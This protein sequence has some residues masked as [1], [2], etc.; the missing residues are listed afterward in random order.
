[1][2]F[3]DNALQLGVLPTPSSVSAGAFSGDVSASFGNVTK[4]GKSEIEISF[5]ESISLG[6]GQYATN[7][8]LQEMP[9]PID[10]TVW[11]NYLAVR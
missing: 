3:W 11:G 8:W 4:P 9:N 1:M 6:N 5:Y 10:R 7:P 2:I